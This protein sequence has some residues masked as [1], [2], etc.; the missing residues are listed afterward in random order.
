MDKTI[1]KVTVLNWQKHNP[2]LKKTHKKFLF[3]TGFF[4]DPAIA[5][6]CHSDVLLYVY[7]LCLC[8]E[9]ASSDIRLTSAGLPSSIRRSTARLS[10]SLSRLESFQLVTTEKTSLIEENR[11]EE[12]RKEKNRIEKKLARP[13][14]AMPEELKNL[15]LL[16]WESYSNAYQKRWQ[17][18]P[19]RNARVNAQISQIANLLGKEA[20]EV[21]EFYVWHNDSFYVKKAHPIGLCLKDAEALRT[22]WARGSAITNSQIK[23]MEKSQH[24]QD[25]I[26][27]IEKGEL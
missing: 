16:C 22:Q 3:Y 24:Y 11:I 26:T 12:K 18:N 4:N 9:G 25:Q 20:P 23:Q 1:F 19:V 15:N 6:L 21:I 7:L 14:R 13:Q 8:G 5:N 2:N 27:R 17:Q 10:S